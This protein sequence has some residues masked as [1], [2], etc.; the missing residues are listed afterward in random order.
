M[1]L[2][3]AL[4]KTLSDIL[5]IPSWEIPYW[6]AYARLEPFGE[7]RA[8]L[9]AGIISATFANANRREGSKPFKPADFMPKFE[10]EQKTYPLDMLRAYFQG[11]KIRQ[12]KAERKNRYKHEQPRNSKPKT[13]DT[14]KRI[15]RRTRPG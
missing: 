13:T 4:G 2:A 6:Y 10:P 14:G 5:T 15:R 1:R 11:L 8:D 12:E 3:L 9:R 7:T